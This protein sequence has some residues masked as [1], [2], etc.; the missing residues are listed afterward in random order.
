MLQNKRMLLTGGSI[1]LVAVVAVV[2]WWLLSPLFIDKTVE[3]EF[4]FAL[5]R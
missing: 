4:P 1:V 3:E 2:A 5:R